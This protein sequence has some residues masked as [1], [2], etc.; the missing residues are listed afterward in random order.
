MAISRACAR[1]VRTRPECSSVTR[2]EDYRPMLA[3]LA[4]QLPSGEGWL[5]EVKWDGYR[6]LGYL[7]DGRARLVSRSGNEVTE[8]YPQIASG[9]VAALGG[10]DCVVDGEICAFDHRGRLSF[11]ALQRPE[12]STPIFYEVFDLL[13]LDSK[14]LLELPLRERRRELERLLD[15]GN[16]FVRLSQGF[17][18]GQRLLAV[19]R[20]QHLEGVMAK[21][22]SSRYMEGRRSRQWR[23]IKTHQRQEFVIC[24][25]TQGQGRRAGRFGA[26]VLGVYHGRELVWVGNCGTGFSEQDLEALLAKLV[27]LRRATPPFAS[28]PRMARVRADE[29]V[30]VQPELVCEVRF[31]EWTRHGHLRAPSFVGL[32][33]DKD[34]RQV[35]R[36][37]PAPAVRR[38]SGR[39]LTDSGRELRLTNLDKLFWPAEGITKGEL[40]DYYRAVSA[41]LLPH[42][43][44]RPLTM[45]RYPDG[46]FGKA[47]FQRNAPAQMPDWIARYRVEV[48]TRTSAARRWIDAPLVNDQD[49]LLWMVNMACIEL[50]TWYSRV[51][52]PDRPDWVLFDLDPSQGVGFGET[53][54]VALL[55]KRALEALGLVSY[56][57]TS[58]ADGIHVLVPI[59]RR[60]T[61]ADTR[62]LCTLL[63]RALA[64][65]HPELVTTQWSKARR[66]GVLIDANQN[67]EGKTIASVYSVRARAGAPVSTPLRWEEMVETL[68]PRTFT[69][70]SVVERIDRH[71]DLF[72][73]V[74]TGRQRLE[75]ALRALRRTAGSASTRPAAPPPTASGAG[76]VPSA[77]AKASQRTVLPPPKDKGAIP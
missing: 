15:G 41:V 70:A 69:M 32:R 43:R 35:R 27:Q 46:A 21:R 29:V 19:V 16:E 56:A 48:S 44:Q 67:A 68:D 49:A 25:Y 42:L 66:R 52:R 36:E 20:E 8:R 47:F 37:A 62:Q 65:S 50:H 63:A 14:P 55:V 39:E 12:P 71:G 38:N 61:Y 1:T 33:D 7:R 73:G 72:A 54:Q 64:Q 51:S 17:A 60:Y 75:R 31:A 11:A 58:G 45:R 40:I 26:L 53:V 2:R 4:Q 57:K 59:Q 76:A 18:D 13:E 34:P 10:R 5:F 23:K 74:L 22:L 9:L 3:T 6:A 30:W 24:G 28:A 77:G